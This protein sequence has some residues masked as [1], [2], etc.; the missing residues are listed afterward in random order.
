M[1]SDRQASI[2]GRHARRA[3][4]DANGWCF[5]ER[6]KRRSAKDSGLAFVVIRE[7]C[8][9]LPNRACSHRHAG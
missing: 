9:E 2:A 8:R 5:S 6:Q 7:V 1:A 4:R 3:D